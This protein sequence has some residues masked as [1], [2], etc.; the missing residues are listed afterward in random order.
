MGE[1]GRQS[2]A[3]ATTG[4]VCTGPESVLKGTTLLFFFSFS[5]FL[6]VFV[7]LF[8]CLFVF[9]QRAGK[10]EV[11]LKLQDLFE[12]YRVNL[13]SYLGNVIFSQCTQ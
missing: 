13:T 8:V 5:F 2:A 4:G 3:T 7:C 11:G 12:K 9:V 1:A 10:V 6:F